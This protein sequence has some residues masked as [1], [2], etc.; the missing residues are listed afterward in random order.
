MSALTVAS[1]ISNFVVGVGFLWDFRGGPPGFSPGTPGSSGSADSEIPHGRPQSAQSESDE[2]VSGSPSSSSAFSS[3]LGSEGDDPP[4]RPGSARTLRGWLTSLRS[5]FPRRSR[6]QRAVW[7]IDSYSRVLTVVAIFVAAIAVGGFVS[8]IVHSIG[9]LSLPWLVTLGVSVGL[10]VVIA[11]GLLVAGWLG[12]R[13]VAAQRRRHDWLTPAVEDRSS[14][15]V[16]TAV[17]LVTNTDPEWT[18]QPTRIRLRKLRIDGVPKGQE[19]E[20]DILPVPDAAPWVIPP[21][22]SRNFQVRFEIPVELDLRRELA[23]SRV[24]VQD[25]FLR[26]SGAR[27]RLVWAMSPPVAPTVTP[28]PQTPAPEGS[29]RE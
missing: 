22:Q 18:I 16:L 29:T 11:L 21:G 2:S 5:E 28:P 15:P 8:T 20:G 3:S 24:A 19:V 27:Q 12:G 1:D 9:K 7:V 26:W 6:L 25:Q 17:V 10:L 4:P 23:A 14:D 13:V